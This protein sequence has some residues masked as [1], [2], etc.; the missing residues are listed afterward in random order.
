MYLI[1]LYIVRENQSKE[2]Y[3]PDTVIHCE[4]EPV[5]REVWTWI[6][7][8]NFKFH[9]THATSDNKYVS[10]FNWSVSFQ[11]IRLQE[12]IKDITESEKMSTFNNYLFIPSL[13]MNRQKLDIHVY[14][15]LMAIKLYVGLTVCLALKEI[16][17][18][19]RP[20]I[21]QLNVWCL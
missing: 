20:L 15:F 9:S 11:K 21:L 14:Y 18:V 8:Y 13:S 19:P 4:G 3:V 5:K 7:F 16:I 17:F 10:L 2:R 6:C 1:L 12:Y